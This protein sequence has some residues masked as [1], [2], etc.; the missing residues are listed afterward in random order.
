[1]VREPDGVAMSSRNR[2]L[3]GD[4]RTQA[5]ALSQALRQAKEIVRRHRRAA[6][7]SSLNNQPQEFIELHP[8]ARADSIEFSDPPPLQRLTQVRPGAHMALAVFIGRTRLIDNA[9]L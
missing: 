3:K 6:K 4:R 1:T 2:Y 5:R 9:R 8:A 7:A